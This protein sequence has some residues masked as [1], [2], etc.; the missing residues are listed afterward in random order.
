MWPPSCRSSGGVSGLQLGSFI[1]QRGRWDIGHVAAVQGSQVRIEYFESI[2]EPI[3]ES[4]DALVHDCQ[5]ITLSVGAR[6]FWRDPDT[7][8]WTAGR[9]TARQGESYFVRFPNSSADQRVRGSDLRVRWN[10]PV[11]DPLHVLTAGGSEPWFFRQARMPMLNAL[12]WQRAACANVPAF[13]S[14]AVEL[15]PHQVEASLAVLSDPVQRYLLA[16]E[17]GLGKTVEAG[18]V[19]RQILIDNPLA[20][21]TIVAPDVLRR[22][23][24]RELTGKFFTDDFPRA[25]IKVLAHENPSGWANH[26]NSDLLV[27]DEAHVLVQGGDPISSPYRE[28]AL[29]AHTSERLLL[30]SA[31]PITSNPLT[32][33]G[34]LHLLDPDVYRWEDQAAFETRYAL[35]AELA[36]V[37]YAIDADW[38]PLLPMNI[39]RIRAILPED[40]RV[41]ELGSAV[42]ALLTPDGDLADVAD[43]D[44]LRLRVDELRG[45]ISETYRLH[46]RTIRHRRSRVLADRADSDFVPYEVRGRELPKHLTIQSSADERIQEILEEWRIGTRDAL[47]D[48]GAADE[49]AAYA[50]VY[51][52]LVSRLGVSGRD[53]LEI[54]RLRVER[55][56]PSVAMDPVD[57]G[58]VTFPSVLAHEPRTLRAVEEV[59]A[60][61]DVTVFEQMTKALLPVLS[62]HRKTIAFCGGGALAEDLAAHLRT[63]FPKAPLF[64]HTRSMP[65]EDAEKSVAGWR[66][67]PTGLLVCDDSGED[68]LN[69]QVADAAIHLRL[70]WSPNRLEQR[71]GRVDRFVESGKGTPRGPAANYVV[72]PSGGEL[73]ATT[74]WLE[75]LCSGYRIFDAS[76]STLQDAISQGLGSV[77]RRAL[78]VGTDALVDCSEEVE[79]ALKEASI[80]IDKM[81]MLESIHHSVTY[82]DDVAD[83]MSALETHW[84]KIREA[85]LGYTSGKNGGI[86]IRR[87]EQSIDGRRVEVFDVAGSKPRV[88]PSI[89]RFAGSRFG[90]DSGK[91]VFNRSVAVQPPG[92]R[93]FRIGNPVVDLLA[94]IIDND[95]RGQATCVT[96]IDPR[97]QDEEPGIYFGFDLLFEA[98]L[99]AATAHVPDVP[100]AILAL[101]RRADRLFAPFT[102]RAWVEV[103]EDCTVTGPEITRWLERPLNSRYDHNVTGSKLD[104]L[105]G[106]FGGWAGFRKAGVEAEQLV[107]VH[108]AE[109]T[110]LTDRSS[111]ALG[112]ATASMRVMQAQ[113][114]ARALAGR[115]VN[116]EETMV[117]DS[118]LTSALADGI[119]NPSARVVAAICVA[120]TGIPRQGRE[121]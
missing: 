23:W 10:R 4:V 12:V 83:A 11:R 33:L 52:V 75:L 44:E 72:L 90:E 67:A 114:K 41:E 94:H 56:D 8:D 7:H 29:L 89:L 80:E 74:A 59:V 14:S 47:L 1:I 21:V 105:V 37:A 84:T 86:D 24:I 82:S 85:V 50:Q 35:R 2:A 93:I 65:A 30:L 45:H 19:I 57:R 109:T 99:Q 76:V 60:E 5:L 98:D 9:V 15:F 118:A 92:R 61:S 40:Q 6:V 28:L 22:Q 116:D 110:K 78:D 54:L 95:D 91:G 88:D 79:R 73:A 71:L 20:K 18:F 46:R 100:S 58:L 121:F 106:Q 26:K 64:R 42:L 55:I 43:E 119:R 3:A 117:L 53:L 32:H 108:L 111:A 112:R 113:A 49:D 34:L 63:R 101:R 68:G 27:V 36:D 16:D 115:L 97:Y 66:D 70:P 31:T 120:R 51:G 17:V 13:F 103:G 48:R 25:E 102:M 104:D 69:L 39:D 107:R 62:R 87:L 96:R 81:D 77:W 38:P